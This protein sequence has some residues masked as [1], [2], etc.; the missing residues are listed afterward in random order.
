VLP[1]VVTPTFDMIYHEAESD[2][3]RKRLAMERLQDVMARHVPV[4]IDCQLD[5]TLGHAAHELVAAAARLGCD[6][7]VMS[8]HGTGGWQHLVLGSVA[9]A[10]ARMANCPVL[11]V[12]QRRNGTVVKPGTIKTILCPTDF[13]P[14]S[15]AALETGGELADHWAASLRLL[16]VLEPLKPVLGIVAVKEFVENCAGEAAHAML[17]LI[18]QHVPPTLQA[19]AKLHRLISQGRT[20]EEIVRRAMDEEADL[21]VMGTHG[22]TGLQHMLFGS[23]AEEVVRTAPCLVLTLHAHPE[24]A[25]A[26]AARGKVEVEV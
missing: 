26:P 16:H 24:E 15:V 9:E 5:V 18:E 20:A 22:R 23:V 21:I 2:E 14:P 3:A 19:D 11:T 4:T 7:L 1:Y 6:L 8:T 12:R 25:V 13:S 17:P 10:V